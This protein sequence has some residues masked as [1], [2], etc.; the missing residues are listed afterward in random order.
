MSLIK[1]SNKKVKE[2]WKITFTDLLKLF[3]Q[4]SWIVVYKIV[5]LKLGLKKFYAL[6]VAKLLTNTQNKENGICF[7][8]PYSI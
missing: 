5:T 8:F 4:V 2:N 7:R 1:K 6:W 3:P